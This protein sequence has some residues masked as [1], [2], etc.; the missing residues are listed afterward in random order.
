MVSALSAEIGGNREIG[1]GVTVWEIG[2]GVTVSVI[3][4]LGEI[5]AGVTVSVIEHLGL[6]CGE[7]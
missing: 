6:I 7:C 2:A 1:A 5:G 3:E 4:H